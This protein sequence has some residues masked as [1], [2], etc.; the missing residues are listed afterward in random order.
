MT[1]LLD[2][3]ARQLVARLACRELSAEAVARAVI[4]RIEAEEGR[5]KAWS[6]FNADQVLAQA[7]RLDATS[8]RGVFHGLPIGVKDLMD[9]ADMPTTYGSPI[10]AGHRPRFDAAAVAAA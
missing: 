7:R 4:E 8:I 2:L 1:D 5:L 9:T 10:Y 6:Y 3:P